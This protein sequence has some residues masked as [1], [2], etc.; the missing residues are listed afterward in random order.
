[1]AKTIAKLNQTDLTWEFLVLNVYL[2]V[3]SPRA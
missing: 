2:L 1:L 3:L